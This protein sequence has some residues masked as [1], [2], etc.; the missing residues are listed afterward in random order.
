MSSSGDAGDTWCLVLCQLVLTSARTTVAY[1][2]HFPQR[3]RDDGF[4][5][6]AFLD[7]VIIYDDHDSLRAFCCS[8]W[9][10]LCQIGSISV[11]VD[12]QKS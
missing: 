11:V 2:R 9:R 1:H 7:P 5:D 4:D 3:R 6:N 8:L 12:H 10:T